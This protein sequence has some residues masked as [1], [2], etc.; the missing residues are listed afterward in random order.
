MLLLIKIIKKAIRLG[1]KFFFK[2]EG[3]GENAFVVFFFCYK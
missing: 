1:T 3:N 2:V